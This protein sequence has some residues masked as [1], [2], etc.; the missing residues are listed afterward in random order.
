MNKRILVTV[1]VDE[2]RAAVLEDDDLAEL[3]IERAVQQRVVGNI[4]KGKVQNVLPGMQ[5]AFVDI[6]LDRNAFLYVDDALMVDDDHAGTARRPA[7]RDVLSAGQ[8]VLVQVVKEPIGT[9][10]ARVTRHVTLPG[11]YLVLMPR[12]DYIGVSRRIA[13]DRERERLREA[14]LAV[15]PPGM[16]VIVRTVSEGT[17][18]EEFRRDAGFLLRLWERIMARAE[19]SRAPALVHRDLAL[20]DRVARDWLDDQVTELIIDDRAEYDHVM[21]YLDFSVPH[22]RDRVRLY[23]RTDQTLF[24]CYGVEP[25]IEKLL[26]RRIWLKSGGYV[27]L[28]Q[29]EALTAIDVNTGKYVGSTNLAETVFKTNLEAAREI[30]RQ[31][32]LRDIGGIIIIDFI[33]MDVH[34]HRQQVLKTLEQ[35]LKRDRTR[36]QVLGLTQLGLV[37]LTRKKSR[38]SLVDVLTHPCPQC[39]GRGRVLS[40]ETMARRVR[41]ELRRILK[42]SSN[43]AVLMEVNPA[44]AALVIGPKGN[45]LRTLERELGKHIFVRGSH[46]CHVH[47]MH[48]RALGTLAE[49]EARALPVQVG[50]HLE[51]EVAEP[52]VSNPVDGIARLDGYVIDIQGAGG[53]VGQRV[54]IEVTR[55]F[56]TYARARVL[57]PVLTGPQSGPQ[58]S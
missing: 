16:G 20:V 29:T 8:E 53:L 2:I 6:G 4:Y 11:R 21:D 31:L 55:A 1:D 40:E 12:T 13:G 23:T 47:D 34:E 39:E 36:T 5:A 27:V 58:P 50:Q 22:L 25:E 9:K 54:Q 33:D 38:Q 51:L 42:S 41:A 37:E 43:E 3:V 44:V 15:K 49:V 26:K 10:G 19:A 35:E 48:L 7:I 24:D 45:H 30:A 57:A 32:R 18:A 46:D 28:D 52:H 14:A 56:R 17:G